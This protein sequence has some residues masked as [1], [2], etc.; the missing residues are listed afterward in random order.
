MI[1]RDLPTRLAQLVT[2]ASVFLMS[3][4][5]LF[6]AFGVVTDA[7]FHS[8]DTGADLILKIWKADGG[9]DSIV[10][11]GTELSRP[12]K[13][14]AINSGLGSAGTTTSVSS[15]ADTVV[16]TVATDSTNKLVADLKHYYIVR[17]G[18]NTLYMATYS[19]KEPV[20]GELRWITRLEAGLFP[21][22]PV[23]SDLRNNKGFIE[24]TDVF[25]MADGTTCSKYYG[26]QQT[27][28][29]AVRG[30]TGR[31]R[32][33]FMV[34]GNR[35][36]SS[37]GPFFRDIQNQTDSAVE[38]YNYLNSG[39]NQTE[40]LRLGVLYGPYALCFT[41][42][43][44]PAIPDMSF[45]AKLGLT[46]YVGAND[47]GNVVLEGLRGLDAKHPYTV[48]FANP[49]AQYLTEAGKSGG[50][51]K[52]EG[53]KPGSY[54]MTIYKGELA[55]LTEAV[56]I[57]A[58]KSTT[59]APLTI[60]NDPSFVTPIWRIGDWDGAPL[61]FRNGRNITEMHPS[62]KRQAEW[63]S[64]VFTVGKCPLSD[65]PACQWN[66]VND[67][68]IIEFDLTADQ[69]ADRTLRIGLSA[70]Y[71]SARPR[72]NINGW[73]SQPPRASV[74]PDSRS[75]TIGT[76]RGNNA[77][78]NFKIPA[79]R[80]VVGTN[81]LRIAVISGRSGSRFLSPGYAIDCVDFF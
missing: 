47:R 53:M 29:L 2:F 32:G 62:D 41:D 21:K 34:Y 44:M 48:G 11:N 73:Q 56:A 26:N 4:P 7:K 66:D 31:G 15:T 13:D 59:L 45:V 75:I 76:Y 61:E 74:Q 36:S 70:T 3:T 55:V 33:V 79:K 81:T 18:E 64:G 38:I 30:V 69:I 9:I 12:G 35:E 49:T 42:G 10:F 27:R 20:R 78:F 80:L 1:P 8:V 22:A 65:F 23:W 68:Q 58:G 60:T 14:S 52:C 72:I 5:L 19:D 43:R 63:K 57:S 24:S 71:A 46:G 67:G 17:N 40:P 6:G 39:H 54:T 28:E 77:T 50:S 16:I 25:G 37:G 51:A